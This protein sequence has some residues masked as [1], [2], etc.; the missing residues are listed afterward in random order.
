[1]YTTWI[2]TVVETSSL[3]IGRQGRNLVIKK[4]YCGKDVV[5][6]NYRNKNILD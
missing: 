1:M 6:R 4:L 2:S 5:N 3:S